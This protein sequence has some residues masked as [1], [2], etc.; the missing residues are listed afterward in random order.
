VMDPEFLSSRIISCI[1]WLSLEPRTDVFRPA[2]IKGGTTFGWD[3][4][5]QLQ[6]D[7]PGVKKGR[8]ARSRRRLS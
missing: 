6:R 1:P 2:A 7:S 3:G 5:F 8:H 4:R